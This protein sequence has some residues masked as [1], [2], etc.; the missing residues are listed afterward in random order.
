MMVRAE[1]RSLSRQELLDKVY[2]KG[3]NYERY[4][5]S[6]S[7]STVA[8]LHDILG[9][10][11]VLVRASTSSSGGQASHFIGTCGGLIGGAM[12]LDRYFGRPVETLSDKEFNN[13]RDE[14][15]R[16]ASQIVK[17]LYYKYVKEYGT[18]MCPSL[19][20]KLYGRTFYLAD[21]DDYRKFEEAGGHDDPRITGKPSCCHL[22]G[23]AAKWVMEIL[24]D[25][26]VVEI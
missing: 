18:T 1:Y 16:K 14:A 6:C 23:N 12:V 13:E 10:E 25:K 22:V 9:F 26:G 21:S 24:L 4:S 11:D 19:Q 2:D 8:A 20:V 5:H 17:L 7:Q 3:V 15:L